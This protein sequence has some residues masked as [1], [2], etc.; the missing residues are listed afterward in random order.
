MP[1]PQP[2]L[3]AGQCAA[4]GR[5]GHTVAA[6]H[7]RHSCPDL[8]RP[9]VDAVTGEEVEIRSFGVYDTALG[10]VEEEVAD[11]HPDTSHHNEDDAEDRL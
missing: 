7:L 10:V 11:G 8:L 3:G 2:L 5:E 1:D 6:K 4:R 9:V